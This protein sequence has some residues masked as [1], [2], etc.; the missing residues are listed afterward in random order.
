MKLEEGS[1]KSGKYQCRGE[2]RDDDLGRRDPSEA[3][4]RGEKLAMCAGRGRERR[5]SYT[6]PSQP[7]EEGPRGL[8]RCEV[9]RGESGE[10]GGKGGGGGSGRV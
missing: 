2:D 10:A 4:M 6:Q 5:R 7:N 3:E 9:T 8:V 1:W